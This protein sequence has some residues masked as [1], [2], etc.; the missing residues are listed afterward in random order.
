[1]K[2]KKSFKL[3]EDCLQDLYEKFSSPMINAVS[4]EYNKAEASIVAKTLWL[5]LI[6]NMDSDKNLYDILYLM[7]E[8]IPEKA[9]FMRKYYKIMKNSLSNVEILQLHNH[10]KCPE[11][12]SKLMEWGYS[13]ETLDLLR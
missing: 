8:K 12:F 9:L 3:D 4:D 10:F 6:T 1:M 11:N 2:R 5:Y 13:K 7:V